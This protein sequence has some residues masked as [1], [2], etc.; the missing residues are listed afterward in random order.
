MHSL[1]ASRMQRS[2]LTMSRYRDPFDAAKRLAG[3]TDPQITHY[4]HSSVI[5]D[6]RGR[7]ISTGVNHFNGK[8]VYLDVE[9]YS[10]DKT[11]HSEVHALRK[12]D[13]R[14]LQG[15]VIINYAK[16]NIAAILSRPCPNCWEILA[17]LGFRKVFYSVRS[18]LDKPLWVEERF[19]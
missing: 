12:V 16:T 14:R 5:L 9:G 8:S 11:I 19:Q 1:T 6:R 7:I 15:A 4:F 17:G 2:I 3:K 18:D 10:I 13:I